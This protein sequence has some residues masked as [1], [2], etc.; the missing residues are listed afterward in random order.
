MDCCVF[1]SKS[2]QSTGISILFGSVV[3]TAVYTKCLDGHV[4][5]FRLIEEE[6]FFKICRTQHNS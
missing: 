6:Q 4:L 5:P 3:D 1:Y 2:N